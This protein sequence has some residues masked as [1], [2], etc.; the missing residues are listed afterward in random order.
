MEF[1]VA[2]MHQNNLGN[3]VTVRIP[4]RHSELLKQEYLEIGPRNLHFN[5]PTR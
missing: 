3:L 2:H 4:R 1:T 5:K